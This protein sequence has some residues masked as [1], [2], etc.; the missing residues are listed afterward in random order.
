MSVE[1]VSA[2]KKDIL[3]A[4]QT[5]LASRFR[6]AVILGMTAA[7]ASR[8]KPALLSARQLIHVSEFPSIV[9]PAITTVANASVEP[10]ATVGAMFRKL[11]LRFQSA[12]IL[13]TIA[14]TA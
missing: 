13:M 8:S 4:K 7:S 6:T 3:G 10:L 5:Q 2:L 1:T 9:P 14:E 12:V 11:A